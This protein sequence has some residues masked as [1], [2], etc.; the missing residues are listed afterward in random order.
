MKDKNG[1]DIPRILDK[2]PTEGCGGFRF[3][4]HG[5]T[6]DRFYLEKGV[7]KFSHDYCSS[8]GSETV[9]CTE[10]NNEFKQEDFEI[11]Q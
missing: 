5:R 11:E 8:D 6:S 7:L 4:I 9:F 1:N 2:C 10:C 3:D